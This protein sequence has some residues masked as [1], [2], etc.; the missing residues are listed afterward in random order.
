M[1]NQISNTGLGNWV[2]HQRVGYRKLKQGKKS[3]I[4]T[5][6]ALKLAEIGF[7]FVARRKER[8]VDINNRHQSLSDDE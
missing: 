8:N 3:I 5:A 1:D 2:H 7:P 6:K 4:T